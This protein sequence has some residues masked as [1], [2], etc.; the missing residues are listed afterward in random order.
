M[1]HHVKIDVNT[2][3]MSATALADMVTVVRGECRPED[4]D[5]RARSGTGS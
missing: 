4:R 5:Q 3:V 2:G 1:H